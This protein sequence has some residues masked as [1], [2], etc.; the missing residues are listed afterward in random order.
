[1][2]AGRV[3]WATAYALAVASAFAGPAR[4]SSSSDELV[5]QARTHEASHEDDVAVRR[6]TEA[7]S[8]DPLNT[9]A[10]IGLGDLRMRLGDPLEAERVYGAALARVPALAIARRRRANARWALHRHAEAEADL[11]EYASASGDASAYRQLADW[12]GSDGRAPGQLAIWR[13]ILAAA[14][15]A[16]D[17]AGLQDAE[18]MVRALV[19]LVGEADPA[20]SPLDGDETR[21]GLAR[22]AKRAR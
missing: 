9:D 4:A 18:R 6:Y 12:L 20:S 16:D 8:L 2:R 5:R 11:F 10:W 15:V 1:M 17:A 22:I 3:S 7:L 14:I 21:R 19:V 13:H